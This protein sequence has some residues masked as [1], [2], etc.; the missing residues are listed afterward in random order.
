LADNSGFLFEIVT[1]RWIRCSA[2]LLTVLM[3]A[4]GGQGSPAD[5]PSDF[6]A[7]S[8]GGGDGRGDAQVTLNWTAQ[9][10]L[11]YW[12]FCA[13]G[14]TVDDK[15]WFDNGGN[16]YRSADDYAKVFNGG[17]AQSSQRV[18][19]P[20]NVTGLR[21]DVE[22]AFTVNARKNGGPGGSV[23]TSVSLT[24]RLAGA[25]WLP[26]QSLSRAAL[27]GSAN[28][29]ALSFGKVPVSSNSIYWKVV[30]VAVGESGAV[31]SSTDNQQTWTSR[32]LPTAV[33]GRQL[34]DLVFGRGRFIA[35]GEA[36]TIVYSADGV[37]W[38]SATINSANSLSNIALNAVAFNNASDFV[39]VGQ[40]GTVLTSSDG[41]TWT[42][43]ANS[44]PEDLNA[45]TYS[46]ATSVTH[47][48]ALSTKAFWLAAG[49]DG[50]VYTSVNA[51]ATWVSANPNLGSDS[52]RGVSVLVKTR[53]TLDCGIDKISLA[54]TPV[55]TRYAIALVGENGKVATATPT[56]GGSSTLAPTLAWTQPTLATTARF[57]RV[58]SPAGQ[59]LAVGN[60][61]LIYTAELN[62]DTSSTALTWTP[63]TD[64]SFSTDLHGVLRYG[65]DPGLPYS[66]SY[67]AYGS[68]GKTLYSR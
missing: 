25:T 29:R 63:R 54:Q 14:N 59:F 49:A 9:P 56:T 3:V 64:L 41:I 1:M 47:P 60:G 34:N 10:G 52:W 4:C 2:L 32:S 58:I 43:Q 8:A 62:A 16:A 23:A 37:T 39:A 67:I 55:V 24:P 11:E 5:P 50:A 27:P 48:V 40:G 35:V 61:G 42:A 19:P 46:A 65:V 6:R 30:F 22:Y 53:S 17:N 36:G 18:T 15:S 66:N 45:I 28:I 68:A 33:A 31:Y 21:N 26:P 20:F 51:G 44:I 7:E 57:N 13:P 38:T 12:I